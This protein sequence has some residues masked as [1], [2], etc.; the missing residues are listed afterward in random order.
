M[1]AIDVGSD[2]SVAL[3][4]FHAEGD[5]EIDSARALL[6]LHTQRAIA[7]FVLDVTSYEI[8]NALLRGRPHIAADRVA[9]VLHGLGDI[10]PRVSLSTVEL[11]EAAALTEHHDLTL[12]DAANGAAARSRGAQLATLDKALLRS[13][14]GRRPSEIVAGLAIG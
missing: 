9:A 5:E 13:C 1:P 3:K 8:G 2:A 11:A 10:C 6:D 12:Y 7:L 14:L 4:S